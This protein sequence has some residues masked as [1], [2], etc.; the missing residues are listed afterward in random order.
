MAAGILPR[1]QGRPA[2]HTGRS[3]NVVPGQAHTVT[4]QATETRKEGN[5]GIV[6]L[7][8]RIKTQH[9]IE[10]LQPGREIGLIRRHAHLINK[11]KQDVWLLLRLWRHDPRK[12]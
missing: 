3:R 8:I 9:L 4:A 10:L 12:M 5:E 1:E 6:G 7:K 11:N 2:R